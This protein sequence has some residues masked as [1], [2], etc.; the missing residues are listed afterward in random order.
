[1]WNQCGMPSER[2][3]RQ[4]ALGHLVTIISHFTFHIPHSAFR[5][6]H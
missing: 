6:P 3:T 1:M 5:I 2:G 4:D